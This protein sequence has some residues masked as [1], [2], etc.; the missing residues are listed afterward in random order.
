MGQYGIIERASFYPF[1][2]AQPLG[3]LPVYFYYPSNKMRGCT[4]FLNFQALKGYNFY[5]V[6]TT[7]YSCTRSSRVAAWKNTDPGVINHRPQAIMGPAP[8]S[9]G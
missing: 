1:L 2:T 7:S 8:S 9:A 3:K 6:S 4:D 5:Q